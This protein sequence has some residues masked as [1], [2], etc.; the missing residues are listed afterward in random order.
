MSDKMWTCYFAL[1]FIANIFHLGSGQGPPP[2]AGVRVGNSGSSADVPD[3]EEKSLGK[4]VIQLVAKHIES[5][6]PNINT[7]TVVRKVKT[8]LGISSSSAGRNWGARKHT[9][10]QLQ[11]QSYSN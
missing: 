9:V 3:D 8:T 4:Q 11:L 10:D 5:K 7:D 1:I 6:L 2:S